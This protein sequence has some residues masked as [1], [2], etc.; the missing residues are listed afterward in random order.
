MEL[1]RRQLG[2]RFRHP[3]ELGREFGVGVIGTAMT[4]MECV[5]EGAGTG[6]GGQRRPG[7]GLRS[8]CRVARKPG[9]G[10]SSKLR[11]ER[12]SGG[13]WPATPEATKGDHGKG[14]CVVYRGVS[15][16][17][18]EGFLGGGGWMNPLCSL[19]VGPLLSPHLP[20]L[21]ARAPWSPAHAGWLSAC[22]NGP[23]P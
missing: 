5:R 4:G 12:V 7:T 16:T 19:G 13:K 8:G 6:A 14:P 1:P 17:L 9:L 3:G 2:V 20:Q 23:K 18:S 11:G 21:E 22:R 15:G 10:G